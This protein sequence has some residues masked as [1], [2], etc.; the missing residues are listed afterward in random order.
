VCLSLLSPVFDRTILFG[1]HHRMRR[2]KPEHSWGKGILM[3]IKCG[4]ILFCVD[5][6]TGMST[7]IDIVCSNASRRRSH[8]PSNIVHPR[9]VYG[10]WPAWNLC[11][12]ILWSYITYVISRSFRLPWE[13]NTG[14]PLYSLVF[15]FVWHPDFFFFFFFFPSLPPKMMFVRFVSVAVRWEICNN[16]WLTNWLHRT[17]S[18]KS[19]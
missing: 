11:M 4:V 17:E 13:G 16:D 19:H 8:N 15:L 1:L 7:E 9:P 14:L 2:A 10:R 5:C 18:L 12:L 6:F 3:R